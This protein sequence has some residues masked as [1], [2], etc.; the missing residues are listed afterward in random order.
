MCVKVRA[1]RVCNTYYISYKSTRHT[2]K[3]THTDLIPLLEVFPCDLI[4][5]PTDAPEEETVCVDGGWMGVVDGWMGGLGQP[6]ASPQ[7]GQGS[8]YQCNAKKAYAHYPRLTPPLG[9]YIN[10]VHHTH[11]W[12]VSAWRCSSV[13]RLLG[14][15]PKSKRAAREKT[16]VFLLLLLWPCMGRCVGSGLV[17][18]VCVP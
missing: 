3:Q 12:S 7:S 1:T 9:L 13:K 16:W 14:W 11:P 8:R 15:F 6:P 4:V 2:N 10:F 5:L 18:C 17:V